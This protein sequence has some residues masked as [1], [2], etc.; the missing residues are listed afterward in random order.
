MVRILAG[1]PLP[2]WSSG[3]AAQVDTSVSELVIYP[4]HFAGT[5][6]PEVS[7]LRTAPPGCDMNPQGS[8][9]R[10]TI[11]LRNLRFLRLTGARG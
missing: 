9:W 4:K 3:T 11:P 1:E 5:C 7:G 10:S 6:P 2:Y 8:C